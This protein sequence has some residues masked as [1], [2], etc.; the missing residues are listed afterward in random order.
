MAALEAPAKGQD[1][2]TKVRRPLVWLI[3]SKLDLCSA[4]LWQTEPTESREEICGPMRLDLFR[5][6][7]PSDLRLRICCILRLDRSSQGYP[8]SKAPRRTL[9]AS[10]PPA[11][12]RD[13]IMTLAPATTDALPIGVGIDTARYGH[14]VTFLRDDLQPAAPAFSFAET[15]DGYQQLERQ[16]QQLQQRFPTVHFHVRLDAA[17]QYAANL[18]AF[19]QPVPFPKT[20][21]IG[22]PARNQRYRQALFPKRKSDPVESYCRGPLCLTRATRE[23]LRP[24]RPLSPSCARRSAGWKRKPGTRHA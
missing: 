20:L 14:H 17:G 22:E 6:I 23:R 18:E 5:K 9:T 4:Q 12:I 24:M 11:F 10:S 2:R 7:D 16:F 13:D 8:R 21:S 19:L 15:R 1:E 3:L